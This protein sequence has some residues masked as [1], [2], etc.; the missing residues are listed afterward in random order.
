MEQKG[1][2]KRFIKY[3]WQQQFGN[4]AST[5]A[6]LSTLITDVEYDELS[7]NLLRE[8]T[9]LIEWCA[10]NLPQRL[11]GD[12]AFIQRELC[13]YRRIPLQVEIRRLLSMRSRIMSNHL[14]DVS[15][16]LA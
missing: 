15:G 10:P 11:Q 2:F 6:R 1:L 16:L 14:L 4:L 12:L 7:K 3:G 8:A 5:L 9:L 13:Y